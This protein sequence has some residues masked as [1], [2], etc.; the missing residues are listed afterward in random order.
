MAWCNPPIWL[1]TTRECSV[2]IISSKRRHP[3]LM[4]LAWILFLFGIAW[5]MT[6]I[7]DDG[8]PKK[9]N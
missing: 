1:A 8:P 3:F 5:G 7:I 2:L 4:A 9:S 6:I